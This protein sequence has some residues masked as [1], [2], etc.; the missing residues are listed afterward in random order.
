MDILKNIENYLNSQ[1][2]QKHLRSLGNSCVKNI[3]LKNEEHVDYHSQLTLDLGIVLTSQLELYYGMRNYIL[4]LS[5]VKSESL[6]L[7]KLKEYVHPESKDFEQLIQDVPALSVAYHNVG[8]F[9]KETDPMTI[10][11]TL[12]S[13][14]GLTDLN[15]PDSPKVFDIMS[16]Q[17]NWESRMIN[18][19]N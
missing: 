17:S 6:D 3:I 4:M 13:K 19:N 11:K 8:K 15:L 18:K 10:R 9:L 14:C 1:F 16:N 5:D 2:A 7:I 12:L